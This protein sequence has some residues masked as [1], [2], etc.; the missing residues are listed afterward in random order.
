MRTTIDRIEAEKILVHEQIRRLGLG[1]RRVLR[2]VLETVD[3]DEITIAE[4]NATGGA[5]DHL[6][7]EPDLY[8]EADLV[9]RNDAYRR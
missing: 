6:A 7:D 5:F 8:S 1:P 9:E 2:V 4:M 3:D